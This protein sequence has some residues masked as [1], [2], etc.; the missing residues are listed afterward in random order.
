MRCRAG[1]F[2]VFLAALIAAVAL[3]TAAMPHSLRARGAAE[4]FGY[5]DGDTLVVIPARVTALPPLCFA[6]CTSLRE[7]R[8]EEGS[9]CREIGDY[10]FAECTSLRRMALP[11]SVTSLGEGVWRECAALEHLALPAG[12]TEI[13]RELCLRA[14]S[15]R[16]ITFPRA[17]RTIGSYSFTGCHSLE[18]LDI[19]AGVVGIG[20]NAFGECRRLRKVVLPAN[21]KSLESYAFAACDSLE[22]L[23]LPARHDMLGEQI[24]ECCNA[25]KEIICRA[26]VPPAF[27]CES[28]LFSPS[29]SAAYSRCSLLVPA[30]ALPLY[31]KARGWSLFQVII[32]VE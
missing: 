7:V 3:P 23:T 17:L 9:L 6:G 12:I 31:R 8:F 19:P 16:S 4:K 11:S 26:T 18:S 1:R 27:E 2:A 21:L 25:L 5:T 13:P 15:L 24:T 32:G 20:S 22:S 10:C 28:Y 14:S 29:D 30:A